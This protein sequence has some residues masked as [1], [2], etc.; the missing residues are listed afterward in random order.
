M[1]TSPGTPTG[2]G[3]RNRSSTCTLTL[4]SGDPIG[5]AAGSSGSQTP[6]VAITVAS[7]GPYVFTRPGHRRANSALSRSAPSTQLRIPGNCSGSS[8]ANND[9]TILADCTP[10]A[11]IIAINAAGSARSASDATTSVPPLDNVAATSNTAASNPND[12]N[13][14]TVPSSIGAIR[15]ARFTKP[16]CGTTTPFGTPVEPD[17]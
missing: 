7:V 15:T 10:E 3:R 16:R 2:T 13:C 14:S 12:A 9:G 4:P 8:C 5:G 1:N 11:R 17:V 6:A